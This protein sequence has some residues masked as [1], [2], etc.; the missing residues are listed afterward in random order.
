[1]LKLSKSKTG[2]S[3]FEYALILGIVGLALATMQV[4]LRRGIQ[5]GIGMV[6]DTVAPQAGSIEL[7][8]DKAIAQQSTT[9]TTFDAT[10]N[11]NYGDNYQLGTDENT[12]VSYPETNESWSGWEVR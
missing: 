8:R 7:D 6:A 5:A 4:Y 12:S 11:V 1:M 2:Q 3:I 9:R 10:Y